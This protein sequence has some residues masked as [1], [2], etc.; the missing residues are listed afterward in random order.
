MGREGLSVASWRYAVWALCDVEANCLVIWAYQ[1]T[2]ITSVMLL[3]CFTIPFV[4]LLSRMFLS[5]RYTWKHIIACLVCVVG[6]FLTVISDVVS[7]KTQTAPKG[8]AWVGDVLCLCGAALYGCSNVLQELL[9][10]QNRKRCEAVGMLGFWGTVVSVV[11]AGLL[12]RDALA[13]CRWTTGAIIW[14]GGFQVCLFTMYVLAS[15]FLSFADATL[16]NLS[17]LTS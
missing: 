2:T 9:L 12:E 17:L 8:P 1:Y 5:A 14:L 11:Q 6:L 4:M 7:G 3:D 16:F 15:I 10:K 13:R